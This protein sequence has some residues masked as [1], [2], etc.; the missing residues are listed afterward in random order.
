MQTNKRTPSI[1]THEGAKAKHIGSLAAL[2]RS[3]MACLLWE[4]GFYEDGQQVGDRIVSLA[5]LV[6]PKQLADLAIEART[7][8][9]I[10]HAPLLLIR[11]LARHP[12]AQGRLI[13]DTIYQVIQRA[14]EVAE[15]LSIY[16]K[17]GK[18]PVSKQVKIGLARA[19]R[20][21]DAYQL[22]KYNRK[23]VVTLTDV[24]KMVHPKPV[25]DDQSGMWKKLL[26]K[27][28]EAPDTWEVGLSGGGDAKETFTRLLSE[29]KLGY[30]A[31]L[32]NLRKMTE[33]GVEYSLIANAL[34]AGARKSR[35]L[36]FRF[37][38]AAKHA[39]ALFRELDESMQASMAGME[40]LP[41]KTLV[42]VDVSGSMSWAGLSSKSELN[43]IDAACALAGLIVGISDQVSVYSFSNNVVQ[44]PT[45]NGLAII[46]RIKDS[47]VHGGTQLGNAVKQMSAID[48]D[49]LIV[50][51]DEQSHDRVPDP[52][53][54][55]NYMINVANNKNG[56]G[57]GKW[58]HIDGFS[59]A[60]VEWIRQYE[61]ELNN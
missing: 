61:K 23:K 60:V 7:K 59:E 18:E 52:I 15:F 49:R 5:K 10:R 26:H 12:G 58:V 28:L 51:T 1:Q 55:V 53:K 21:F 33:S 41:G 57:Y 50:I 13:G 14:D 46:D 45:I 3:V 20:K 32:R 43:R 2:R 38:S 47:Q 37:V 39:P 34:K 36:P 56:V 30:M 11:E 17:D 54:G 25:N 16:W 44:V 31:L 35:A 24:I 22:A 6:T 27:E 48:Y 9:H 40:R 19:L 8:H 4:D 29:K 42:L